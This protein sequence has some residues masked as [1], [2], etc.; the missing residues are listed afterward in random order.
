MKHILKN[1]FLKILVLSSVL[2]SSCT[3]DN[4]E[5]VFNL[6]PTERVEAKVSELK[7]LLISQPN[8]YKAVYFTKNDERGGFT[9]FMQFNA[10]GTVRQTS[11]FDADVALTNSSY[12][13]RLGTTIELVFTTRNHITKGTDPTAVT[14]VINGFPT[15]L[16][17]FGTSVFQYFSNDNGIITFR[18][19]RNSETAMMVLTPTN[20]IDFDNDS[21][22]AV[23]VLRSQIENITS[24]VGVLTPINHVLEIENDNGIER[25]QFSYSESRRYANAIGFSE[26]EIVE[27]SFGVA[28]TEEGLTISPG[29]ELQGETYVDFLYDEA[30]NS[31]VSEVNGTSATILYDAAPAFIN[32]NDINELM[33]LG[34]TGFLFRRSLGA[35]SL[36]SGN[37]DA[38]LN[39]MDLDVKAIIGDDWSVGGYQ[40]ITDFESDDC[41]TT[42]VLELSNIDGGGAAVDYCFGKAVI[43]DSTL[44]L[45]YQGPNGFEFLEPAVLPLINFLSNPNGLEFTRQGSFS[46]DTRNFSN[47]AATF[48]S[49]NE[50]SIRVYG[51]F[52]G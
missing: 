11:D 27:L 24:P 33:E 29:L 5:T 25:Y 48:R 32:P 1:N 8:G 30:T 6:T 2:L 41:A 10:D 51:L 19:I 38:L 20:F 50:P 22:E 7:E 37:H 4:T 44:F 12:D 52:F 34:P 45:N 13:V 16:G 40:L 15:G 23:S 18:D 21:L 14:E 28:Y 39:Q 43:T 9:T 47:A 42:L 3:D 49:L 36:T 26:T 46:S 35:N 31:F 17:F